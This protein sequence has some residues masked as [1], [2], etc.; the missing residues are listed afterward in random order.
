MIRQHKW[1]R[2]LAMA[3]V[4][5]FGI[6]MFLNGP[7]SADHDMQSNINMVAEEMAR[8]AKQCGA[9]PLTPEAQAKLS[10]LLIETSRLL[11]E[12][13]ANDEPKMQM[14]Y[15]REIAAM[16]EEWNPFDTIYGN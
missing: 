7:A 2:K 4:F 5:F 13:A 10:E 9:Q 12:I 14:Q 3:A 6:L 1:N 15:N 16:E 11:K 8:W